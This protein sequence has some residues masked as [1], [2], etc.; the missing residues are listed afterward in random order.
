MLERQQLIKRH[1]QRVDIGAGVA[2][3]AEALGRHVADGPQD[4]AGLGHAQVSSLGQPEVGDPDHTRRVEQQVRGLD[5]PVHHAAGV[6]VAQGA[7]GLQADLGDAAVISAAVALGGGEIRL[8][9]QNRGRRHRALVVLDLLAE[10]GL[11]VARGVG[12]QVFL[13]ESP[14]D[15]RG[16]ET[17]L[18]LSLAVAVGGWRWACALLAELLELVDDHVEALAVDHLHGIEDVAIV[19]ADVEDGHDVGV[20]HPRRGAGLAVEP[21]AGLGVAGQ[22]TGQDLE[23]HPAPSASC[24]AS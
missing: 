7:G 3:A 24:S 8:A 20:V 21:G 19:L 9:R 1:A 11:R 15:E 18:A 16:G 22:R 10:S 14:Q 4:V 17:R 12:G 6:G 23:G 2:L 5:V 13:L